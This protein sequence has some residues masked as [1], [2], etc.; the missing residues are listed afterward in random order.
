MNSPRSDGTMIPAWI[1]G[2]L[3][4][5]DKLEVHRLGLRHRA[6][7]VFLI[8][9]ESI[10]MQRRALEKYHTPGLWANTCC[11]HPHWGEETADCAVRRL[12]QELG[13]TGIV[14]EF[15]ET[16]EYRAEV[17]NGMVEHELVDVFVALVPSRPAVSPDPAEVMET[18]WMP[19][20]RLREDIALHPENY[21]PWIKIYLRDHAERILGPSF[22]GAQNSYRSRA[23]GC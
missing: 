18:R 15:R 12:E 3:Q 2:R 22:A 21:A 9:G 13:I 8:E 23:A 10:L 1:D 19:Y 20:D 16:L 5:A 14:P 4:P 7:S 6:V 17:G 11:T